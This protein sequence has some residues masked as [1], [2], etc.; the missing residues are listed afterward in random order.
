MTDQYN[1]EI[2]YE[3][4][5]DFMGVPISEIIQE[6]SNICEIAESYETEGWWHIENGLTH[7]DNI[8]HIGL[9]G[10]LAVI[11]VTAEPGN[12]KKS[13]IMENVRIA[14][15]KLSRKFSSELIDL[16]TGNNAHRHLLKKTYSD[17]YQLMSDL[18]HL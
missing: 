4:E 9:V 18:R 14:A 16:L 3:D 5:D 7:E 15:P 12:V 2:E 1:S 11:A 17:D 8:Q 10:V 13:E 6:R